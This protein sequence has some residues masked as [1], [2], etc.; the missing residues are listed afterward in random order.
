MTLTKFQ[1]KPVIIAA[2]RWFPDVLPWPEGVEVEMVA[3]DCADPQCG[4]STWDH[5]CTAGDIKPTGRHIIRTLEGPHIVSPGDWVITGVL[6][7]KYPCK[8]E[9]FALTY[10]PARVGRLEWDAYFMSIARVVAQR[11]T[12]DRKLVGAVIVV[13]KAIVSTGYNGAPRGLPDCDN[14]GHLLKEMGGRMSCI[15]TAHAE[16]NSLAQAAR[17][18]ARV[19]GG[20]LYTT[21]STCYDCAKLVINAGIKRVVAGEF[22]A[23]RYGESG[24]AEEMFGQA[25]IYYVLIDN[26]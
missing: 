10:E 14:V 16:A 6:N 7:E 13:D 24:S 9:V 25:G 23:S 17:T 15:R 19:E 1:K 18:G 4:D 21:A 5:Y 22:Y 12:C 8:P 11:A 20:T 2:E 26:S 3:G